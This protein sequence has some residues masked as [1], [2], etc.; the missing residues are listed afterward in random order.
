MITRTFVLLSLAF[1]FLINTNNVFAI[2]NGHECD[3]NDSVPRHGCN[4]GSFCNPLISDP[5]IGTCATLI[6][7]GVECNPRNSVTNHGCDTG[8][9]CEPLTTDP[10]LGTCAKSTVNSIFGKISPPPALADFLKTN[11]TGAGAI[12]D[13]LSRLVILI[14]SIATIALIFMILWGAFEWLVSGGDKE[15]LSSAQKRIINAIIG[16]ILFAI[17]FAIIRVLGTFTGFRLFIGQNAQFIRNEQGAI[18]GIICTD[19][20]RFEQGSTFAE[21]DP[22]EACKKRGH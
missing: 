10:N 16:I 11:P 12:S 8:L 9:F 13:F 14:F 2:A 17:A 4:T 7:N 1:F 20:I 19:G 21:R 5:N 6:A 18:T 15:K 22:D 3:P